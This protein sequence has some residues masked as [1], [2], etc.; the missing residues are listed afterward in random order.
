[1]SASVLTTSVRLKCVCVSVC[2]SVEEVYW[3]KLTVTSNLLS[4]LFSFCLF[5]YHSYCTWFSLCFLYFALSLL[6]KQT[7]THT[8][9]PTYICCTRTFYYAC[10]YYSKPLRLHRGAQSHRPHLH[11]NACY[12]EY[13]V[14]RKK[15][16]VLFKDTWQQQPPAVEFW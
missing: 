7:H 2:V 15:K 9:S 8:H 12:L 10:M 5:I 13:A 14:R 6:P 11:T 3:V 1:M 16:R 4:Q